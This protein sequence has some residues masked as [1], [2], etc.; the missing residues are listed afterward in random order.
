MRVGRRSIDVSNRDKVFF[1]ESGLTK[2]DLVDYY[3]AVADHFV[4]HSEDYGVTIQRFPDGIS[5]DGFYSKNTPDYFPDWIERVQFPRRKG[6]SFDAPV[7]GGK[8]AL[9]YLADQAMITAHLYLS[10]KDDLE[11]PDKMIFDLDPPE[12]T[13][14]YSKARKAAL[15]LRDILGEI[16]L[17]AFVKTTGS[18][19]YHV[20]VP[21]SRGPGFDKV[22]EFARNVSGALI[23]RKPD[24]YTLEQRKDKRGDKIFLDTLRNSYGATAVAPY[25]VRPKEGAPVAVPLDWQEI[26]DGVSPRDFTITNVPER[27]SK[28]GDPWKGMMRHARKIESRQGKLGGAP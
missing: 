22:R 25:S 9:V 18:N 16:E 21:I 10:R 5:D 26:E 27:L 3:E 11:K 23:E 8:A 15:D 19:G 7:I 28:K 17:K 6:G 4:R 13:K 1:P 14:D 2:G 12:D 24:S 20:V